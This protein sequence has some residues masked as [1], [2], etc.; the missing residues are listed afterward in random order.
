[1]RIQIK[2]SNS[3]PEKLILTDDN[4]DGAGWVELVITSDV[5]DEPTLSFEVHVTDLYPALMAFKVKY[6]EKK[7][8]EARENTETEV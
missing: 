2:N 3:E 4:Y 5:D 8:E 7:K 1:M 6:D